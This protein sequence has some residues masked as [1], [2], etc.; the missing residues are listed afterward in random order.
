MGCCLSKL[1]DGIDALGQQAAVGR[2][3]SE[4]VDR[5][6]SVLRRQFD[7]Q[8]GMTEYGVIRGKGRSTAHLTPKQCYARIDLRGP[9]NRSHRSNRLNSFDLLTP[10][11][12][13]NNF[14]RCCGFKSLEAREALR[15]L[16]CREA[17]SSSVQ[18]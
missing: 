4:L 8:F 5:G 6:Q 16:A 11:I 12:E 18:R 17:L 9:T 7:D 15:N 1:I 13:S 14:L 2:E 3:G 10:P